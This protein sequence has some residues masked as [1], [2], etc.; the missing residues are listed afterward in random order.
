[1]HVLL[2]VLVFVAARALLQSSAQKILTAA[3]SP[4]AEQASRLVRLA[5]MR[6]LSSCGPRA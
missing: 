4:V 5:A 3:V 2:A 1:M 6:R